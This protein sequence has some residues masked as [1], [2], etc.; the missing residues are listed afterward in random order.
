MK[1]FVVLPL[2]FAAFFCAG[3]TQSASG[4]IDELQNAD[5]QATLDGG[6]QV[7][8][9]FDGDHACLRMESAGETAEI[10]GNFIADTEQF[11]I[12]V[13]SLSQNYGFSYLPMGDEL[14]LG[15]CGDTI[16]LK[17]QKSLNGTSKNR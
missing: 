15:F 13:P 5:W 14:E 9:S 17:K 12:F 7:S 8:L 1:K 2:L 11:V 6:A 3:C 10:K 16:T 4:V